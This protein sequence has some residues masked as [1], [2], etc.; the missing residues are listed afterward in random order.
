M[1]LARG[2]RPNHE[3][4]KGDAPRGGAHNFGSILTEEL[5]PERKRHRGRIRASRRGFSGASVLRFGLGEVARPSSDL[6]ELSAMPGS[7]S[8]DGSSVL[9]SRSM[10]KRPDV[11][12]T[13]RCSLRT[14]FNVFSI[15]GLCP[16]ISRTAC[17]SR[18]SSDTSRLQVMCSIS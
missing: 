1:H 11:L 15:K 4:V 13:L 16:S 10:P 9:R 8:P 2:R 12:L 17:A 14:E 18:R 3:W 6:V 7:R 5:D